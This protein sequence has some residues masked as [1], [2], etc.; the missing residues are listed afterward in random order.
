MNFVI[1][2]SH[3]FYMPF[4]VQKNRYLERKFTKLLPLQHNHSDEA[5]SSKTV[6]TFGQVTWKF[7]GHSHSAVKA[8]QV[9]KTDSC[10]RKGCFRALFLK[11]SWVYWHFSAYLRITMT[12]SLGFQHTAW[13]QKQA[14]SHAQWSFSDLPYS[15]FTSCTVT[16]I[17]P[18][19]PT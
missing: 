4:K 15:I 12:R 5:S 2:F 18:I 14:Y 8:P 3:H 11:A 10:F 7:P 9:W 19:P 16:S 1:T 17:P 13:P 6:S